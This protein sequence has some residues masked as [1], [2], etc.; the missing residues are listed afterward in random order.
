MTEAEIAEMENEKQKNQAYL[1]ANRI[2]KTVNTPLS[3]E[4]GAMVK[5]IIAGKDYAAIEKEL[6]ELKAKQE[7]EGG[8][9][10]L[11]ANL[12]GQLS[13][14]LGHENSEGKEFSG[15]TLEDCHRNMINYLRNSPKPEDKEALKKL[16]AKAY[17]GMRQSPNSVLNSE[18]VAPIV[19]DSQ[20]NVVDSP[21]RQVLDKQNRSWRG[22]K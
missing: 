9:G 3:E 18:Y 21:I 6:N 22:T 11:D 12:G 16:W 2:P 14:E 1:E 17:D 15:N 19:A 13:R 10:Q 7:K 5:Q 20:N 8:K 4:Q